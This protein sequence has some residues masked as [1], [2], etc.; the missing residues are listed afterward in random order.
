MLRGF[1]K[2]LR[3]PDDHE[4]VFLSRYDQIRSWARQLSKC[5][6]AEAEDLVQD[7]FIDFIHSRPDLSSVRNLDAF[8]YTIVRNIHRSQLQTHLRRRN[9]L[10]T[11][12]DYD[13]AELGLQAAA[14]AR[15]LEVREQLH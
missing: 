14:P 7:A 10:L 13:S 1:A 12:I 4:A 3:R 8:L 5:N 11:A 2:R 6:K 15:L 9:L